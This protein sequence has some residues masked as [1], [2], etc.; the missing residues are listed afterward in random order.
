MDTRTATIQS[1]REDRLSAVK[2]LW[3]I[4]ILTITGRESMLARLRTRLDPQVDCKPVQVIVIKDN[5]EHS[6]GEKRQYAV[7]S[8]TTKYMNFIDDDDMISTNYVEYILAH[9]KRDVYGVGFKGIITTNSK[10]PL[11]FVHR[12]G[13]KWS[14]KPE[15][16]DGA[17]RYLR[18]LNHL[19]PIMTSIAKEIGYKSISM[20]EDYDYALRL[21]ESGLVKDKT[22][23]D[24]FLYYYQYRSNK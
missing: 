19:N 11:E 5:K 24:Q 4:Y 6:I 3:T 17:V 1:E 9:L 10:H 12:A 2:P 14:D 13:L 15:R 20:G 18:P 22:F 7:D 23:I 21:A 8:C 16:Y